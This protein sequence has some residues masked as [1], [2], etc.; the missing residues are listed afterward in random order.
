MRAVNF[1]E[2]TNKL[3]VMYS[4]RACCQNAL[5]MWP[6]LHLNRRLFVL[7]AKGVVDNIFTGKEFEHLK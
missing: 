5:I 1:G 3:G 2:M 4:Y 7:F 6:G